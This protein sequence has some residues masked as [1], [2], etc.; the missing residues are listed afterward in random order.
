MVLSQAVSGVASCV[1]AFEGRPA[2]HAAWLAPMRQAA[3]ARFAALGFPTTRDEEWRFTSV[4]PIADGGFRLAGPS[5]AVTAEGL[6]SLTRWDAGCTR[7]VFVNGRFCRAL[8]EIRPAPDGVRVCGLAEAVTSDREVVEA[9]LGQYVPFEDAAFVALNTALMEDGA[10]IHL[11]RGVV[12]KDPIHLV[13]VTDARG[14]AV[15]THPRNLIVAEAESQATVV[16]SYGGVGEGAYF[17]NPVTEIVAGENAM[18]DHTKIQREGP[19]AFHTGRLAI[20]QYRTSTVSSH[21]VSL[22]G[23]LVRNDI[24]ALLDAEGCACTLNGLTVAAGDQHVDNHLRVE[25]AK[26]HCNSWEYFK[27]IY[28]D[29]ARG[30]FSGRILVA[31]DAQKTD[32]KQ[33]NMSLLLSESALVDSKPQ[34]EIFADDVKCTHGATVGQ[35]DEEAVFYLQSRG[36]SRDAARSLLIY[37]FA[38]ESVGL[39]RVEPLRDQLQDLLFDQLPHGELL[40]F[41]RPYEYSR[42]YSELVRSADRRRET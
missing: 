6:A 10:F 13:F 33:S 12:A 7:L 5:E 2:E 18:V 8:S 35:I 21:G 36:L 26:P 1:S 24:S 38:G 20:H 4:A 27:G 16:E 30:V 19:Q 28:D 34:L 25:H 3:I 42:H 15:M 11:S 14:E 39:V 23:R 29:R 32:A 17:T 37:A 9:H 22:G 31:E 40:R 41:G